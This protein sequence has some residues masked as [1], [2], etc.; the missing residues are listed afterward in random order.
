MATQKDLFMKQYVAQYIA[1]KDGKPMDNVI[2]G[3]TRLLPC[4]WFIKTKNHSHSEI[5][6][7]MI[8]VLGDGKDGYLFFSAASRMGGEGTKA[9]TRFIMASELFDH[10]ERWDIYERDVNQSDVIDSFNRCW[11]EVGKPYDWFGVLL[12]FV[13][14]GILASWLGRKTWYCSEVVYYALTGKVKRIS[15]RRL[16][17]WLEK[18]GFKK[19]ESLK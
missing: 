14:P 8:D 12:G 2:S 15:P 17:W 18:N 13:S 7:K 16:G 9:G 5:G 19:I 6:W 3:W 1:G 10:P 11:Q 4:N